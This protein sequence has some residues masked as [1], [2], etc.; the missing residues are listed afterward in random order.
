MGTRERIEMILG[1]LMPQG[2]ITQLRN[3]PPDADPPSKLYKNVTIAQADLAGF[4][5]LASTREPWQVVEMIS[6]IFGRFDELT[7]QYGIYKVET[8]GDAYIA[9][10]AEWPL[11]D[12]NSPYLVARFAMEMIKATEEWCQQ[13]HHCVRCR[14]GVH[15]GE[16]V[17]GIIGIEMQRYHLFGRLTRVVEVLESTAP[18]GRVQVSTACRNSILE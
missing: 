15:T 11:T 12:R 9:A 14:V 4:T 3:L 17:G 18:E 16:C 2:V 1:T 13:D 5:K 7:D 10:R 6:A 8:Q